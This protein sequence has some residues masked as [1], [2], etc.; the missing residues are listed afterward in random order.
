VYRLIA[1]LTLAWV[2]AA[3]DY[4]SAQNRPSADP[5]LDD[6]AVLQRV[7]AAIDRALIH[8]ARRQY[9]DGSWPSGYGRNVGVNGVALL[10]FMGRGHHPERG[11][12]KEALT[13]G[14]QYL[15]ATQKPEG[16]YDSPNHSHGPMYEHA[17]AAL[18]MVEL[19]GM[20]SDPKMEPSIRKAITLI[21]RSQAEEG[22]WR[23]QPLPRD[24]DISVTVMQVVALRA[25]Q[26]AGVAVPQR[27]LDKALEYVKRCSTE[28]GGFGY[29]PG[30]HEGL[31]RTAAGILSLQL[32]GQPDAIEVKKGLDYLNSQP[33]TW[34]GE[35]FFYTH[36]YAIQAQYQA[37]GNSWNRWH[38]KI[39]ELLLKQ[40]NADG[41]WPV[42][43]GGNEQ[44]ANTRDN[45]YPTAMACLVLEIY[46][47][48]LPAYQR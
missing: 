11:Q 22:G 6:A 2:L 23:Y 18:A 3:S 7:T 17:L 15:L 13:R 48:L 10:A 32:A 26:N 43:P 28:R 40:Q 30:H 41:S 27:T 12:Y 9:P 42:P 35:Y 21:V 5:P 29:M 38:P 36:Y 4:A 37:G 47:H 44:Q 25:A 33:I 46:L 16:M 8:L 24:A 1:L 19:Y 20:T 45:V 14:R 34:G 39:R 31:A